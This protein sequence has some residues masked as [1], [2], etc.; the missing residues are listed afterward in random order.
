MRD[1]PF[2][3]TQL[4][5]SNKV[6]SPAT[7]I[8]WRQ[9]TTSGKMSSIGLRDDP[10]RQ[11]DY[12]NTAEDITVTPPQIFERDGIESTEA[13]TNSF[14]LNELANLASG[15]DISRSFN[16]SYG[17]KL[18]GLRDRMKRRIE[19]MYSQLLLTGKISFS[20]TERTFEQDYSTVISGT[21][22]VNSGT[23]PL[24]L[25]RRE[26]QAF[27][28]ALGMWPDVI[29]MTPYLADAIM[30]HAKTEKYLNKN[31]YD[32]MRVTPRYQNPGVYYVTR[33]PAL[34]I[35]DIYVYSS[36]YVNDS[37]VATE[38]IPESSSTSGKMILLN[39]SQFA[40]GY[41]A[42]IDFELKPDGSP[43]ITD[44]IVKERIPEASEGH[45]KTLSLLSYPLP[46]LY[47]ANACKTYTT[48]IS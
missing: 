3:L 10:A 38:Y 18:Q 21:L 29:L 30:I 44:V 12:K 36:T 24:Q 4:L 25:I 47:N 6:Y 5:G 16:Y 11:I 35:P 37:N 48:T 32:M 26:C 20:T 13:L 17:V 19:Y 8:K 1:E 40:L 14:N 41:A 2:F 7:T 45:A 34:G 15:S 46:I 22:A 43:I 28:Q 23:D 27:S 42:V 31:T 39:T 33:V 9:I